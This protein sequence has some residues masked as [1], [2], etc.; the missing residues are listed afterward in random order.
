MRTFTHIAA[1]I[2]LVLS[3]QLRPIMSRTHIVI[4][5]THQL[6]S[7]SIRT[8]IPIRNAQLVNCCGWPSLLLTYQSL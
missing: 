5:C 8:I 6:K 4:M 1:V 2:A 3:N 7:I